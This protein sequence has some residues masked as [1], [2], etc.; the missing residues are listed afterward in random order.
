MG[1]EIKY[2]IVIKHQFHSLV[3]E[4]ETILGR[5]V[6]SSPIPHKGLDNSTTEIILLVT[7]CIV[8]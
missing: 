6:L 7:L 4:D 2:W 8:A 3:Y 5:Y 1:W